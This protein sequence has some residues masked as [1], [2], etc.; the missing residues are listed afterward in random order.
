VKPIH[1]LLLFG[2]SASPLAFA[3]QPPSDTLNSIGPPASQNAA[4]APSTTVV[5]IPQACPVSMS[6]KQAGATELV[7]VKGGQNPDPESLPRPGQR[8]RLFL[9]RVPKAGKVTATVTV[10][11]LSAHGRVDR[12]AAGDTADI[13]RTLNVTFDREDDK[14]ISADLVLPG[15]TAVKSVKLESLEFEDGSTRDFAGMHMCTVTPDPV[16]LIAGR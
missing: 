1:L 15:F 13:R 12:A 14:T 4:Q 11:G 16:M 2:L 10:R 7:K 9:T 6:A 8:I 5:I 3:Q